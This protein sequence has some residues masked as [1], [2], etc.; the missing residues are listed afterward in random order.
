MLTRQQQKKKI[1]INKKNK[2]DYVR[3]GLSIIAQ[4]RVK[5]I[6]QENCITMSYKNLYAVQRHRVELC[7]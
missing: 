2:A 7:R 1:T 5:V 4:E 6:K 3:P